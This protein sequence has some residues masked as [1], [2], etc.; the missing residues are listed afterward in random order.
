MNKNEIVSGTAPHPPVLLFDGVCNLCNASV[1]WIIKRDKAGIFRFASLQS[2]AGQHLLQRFDLPTGD[3]KTV[4]LTEGENVYT[5]SDVALKV[6][7]LLGGWWQLL[8]IFALVP[9]PLRNLVYD[10]IAANRY[11]WF[12]KR[13]ECMLPSPEW[14]QR[15]L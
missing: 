5:R 12:G 14:K 10:W 13:D 8:R 3:L 1:Q 2:E 9:R 4:V 6:F 7:Q 15:F 11:R